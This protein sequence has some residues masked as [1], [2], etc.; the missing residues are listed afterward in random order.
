MA[1]VNIGPALL[2]FDPSKLSPLCESEKDRR[3]GGP[4][5]D[6]AFLFEL[7][8]NVVEETLRL[9]VPLLAKF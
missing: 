8:L 6:V 1:S 4:R 7:L 9:E 5:V 3:K 2:L